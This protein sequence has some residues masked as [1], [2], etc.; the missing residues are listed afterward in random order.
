MKKSLLFF[1][2]IAG[3]MSA[4]S[5]V[6]TQKVDDTHFNLTD[7]YNEPPRDLYSRSIVSKAEDLCPN[8][9]DVLSKNAAKPAEFGYNDDQ[10]SAY[11]ACDY[12]LEWRIVCVDRPKEPFSLFGRH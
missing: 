5:S 2:L 7:T 11:K 1:L 12:T 10:C 6:Q 8:G 3:T 4:C 9:Y